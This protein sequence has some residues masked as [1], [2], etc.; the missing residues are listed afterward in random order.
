MPG[1]QSI[2]AAEEV[3]SGPD[4]DDIYASAQ[5]N[6]LEINLAGQ[7][8]RK[9][10][11]QRPLLLRYGLAVGS[12]GDFVIAGGGP[13]ARGGFNFDAQLFRIDLASGTVSDLPNPEG[14][15]LSGPQFIGD[16]QL[17]AFADGED[18]K[19]SNDRDHLV[20]VDLPTGTS[21]RLS[22]AG[23]RPQ[24]YS[25]V[26]GTQDVV[27]RAW[28]TPEGSVRHALWRQG[29]SDQQ[30]TMLDDDNEAHEVAVH[31]D[32]KRVAYEQL[33]VP[34]PPKQWIHFEEL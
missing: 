27:Y 8:I 3:R 34:M 1:G 33:D 29:A 13:P 25:V 15:H 18:D 5:S 19:E 30:P 6:L 17:V 32:G 9:V 23:L 20:V 14:A 26:P 16:Q 31:P 11:L 4:P 2:L 24:G 21:H 28:D 12:G 10:A 22:P 7:V